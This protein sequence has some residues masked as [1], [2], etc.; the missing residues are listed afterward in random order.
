MKN[1]DECLKGKNGDE[2]DYEKGGEEV[3]ECGDD[4][5]E[6]DDDSDS[7]TNDPCSAIDPGAGSWP[8]N[9]EAAHAASDTQSEHA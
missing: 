7:P 3:E 1:D 6:N 9:T 4:G 5:Y 8:N 2:T